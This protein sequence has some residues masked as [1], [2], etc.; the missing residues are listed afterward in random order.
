MSRRARGLGGLT[1]VLLAAVLTVTA[2]SGAPARSPRRTARVSFHTVFAPAAVV[3][4][5]RPAGTGTAAS[6]Y[7][8]AHG[9]FALSSGG[10]SLAPSDAPYRMQAT[11]LGQYLIYGVHGDFLGAG[12][13]PTS[14]PTSDTVWTVTGNPVRG[15]TMTNQGTGGATAVR[16]TPAQGCANYPEAGV[17]AT[18]TS[19]RG[20]GPLSTVTGTIDAHTHV[21]AFEFLG[22]DWHCGRPWHPFG[23]EFALP[24]CAPYE[25]GTNGAVESFVDYGTPAHSHDTVGWPTFHDWP[26]PTDLAEEGDYYTGIERAWKAGLRV[27]VTQLVDNEALCNL[28]TTKH[29][30]C[31]DMESVHIQAADL[32][33]L[34]DYIDA[35]SGGPGK[36]FFRIV[37]N[38]FQAR[39]V[40]NAGKLA[41]VEGIEVSDLFNCGEYLG[42]PLCDRN[43]IDA[44]LADVQHLGVS[45]FFPVHK[46]DNAF[47]GTKMDAGELGL[48][49][50]GGNHLET[51]QFWN[52]ETCPGAEHDSTQLSAVPAGGALFSLLNGS[53]GQNLL[54]GLPGAPVPS[55]AS[56]LPV[57]PPAPHCN[58]RGLT[59]LGHYLI[60]QMMRRHLIVELDHMDVKTADDTLSLLEAHHYSGVVSAHSWDSPQEN[61]RIYNLGGFVTPIA[62]S[63]PTSFIDQWKTSET[64][65][66]KRFYGGTGFG[67]GADMNG[68]AEESQPDTLSPIHYPFRAFAGNVTFNREVW[69]QRTFD[70]NTDGVANYGMFADWL[71]ELQQIGGRPL[72]TDMFHGAEAYLEMWERAYG[73]P[74]PACLPAGARLGPSGLGALRLGA[75]ARS[76]L[77]AAGQPAARPGM[78]YRWC[79]TGA[80][81]A[82]AAAV[83]TRSG[84]VR[85]VASSAPRS[86]TGAL[87][88]GARAPR[89]ARLRRLGRSLGHGLWLGHRLR[90]G[91]RRLY[92]VRAGRIA[93]TAVVSGADARH[94]RQLRADARAA[95]L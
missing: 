81:R 15:Y 12:A 93:W 48:L 19:F 8:L 70:L 26:S 34:Q 6:R 1:V 45:T 71:Q 52:I 32:R 43:Q 24:D 90:G 66:N 60:D 72:L 41:V 91:A 20:A 64:V 27:M 23:V 39:Q 49:I 36:G 30:P 74:G 16:F 73:V 55:P 89:A 79:V 59:D 29:N 57:Y 17:D 83:F 22:G 2:V 61:P 88:P 3:A 50:N 76:V 25:T 11:A 85:M 65:R 87:H 4:N 95:G 67:Y 37:T 9:C 40:I 51:G 82:G 77:M 62:G 47:G 63:S 21:T 56:Q 13:A 35:Q 69:G 75:G 68:L 38:P 28:M 94:P 7:S 84:R 86:V 31:N 53:V 46:F 58:T 44:G 33:A 92:R 18:G 54:G 14:Q 42:K 5:P 10:R 78:A 80:R